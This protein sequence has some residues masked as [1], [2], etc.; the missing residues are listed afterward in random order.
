M[1]LNS[2]EDCDTDLEKHTNVLEL[3]SGYLEDEVIETLLGTPSFVI[4]YRILYNKREKIMLTYKLKT[5][6]GSYAKFV[7]KAEKTISEASLIIK[8]ELSGRCISITLDPIK[9]LVDLDDLKL[10]HT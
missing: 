5:K 8:D 1:R 3:E 2:G 9:D 7:L 10:M 4:S 6:E